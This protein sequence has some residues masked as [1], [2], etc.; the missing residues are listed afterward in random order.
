MLEMFVLIV[1]SD[2]TGK[3]PSMLYVRPTSMSLLVMSNPTCLTVYPGVAAHTPARVPVHT[4]CTR[5]GVLT[6]TAHTL[7]Y[8]YNYNNIYYVWGGGVHVYVCVHFVRACVHVYART[9]CVVVSISM[10]DV[11]TFKIHIHVYMSARS[12]C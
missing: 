2:V 12:T 3:W 7:V 11:Y 10:R 9:M 8:V 5:A 4:V 1:S 6:R